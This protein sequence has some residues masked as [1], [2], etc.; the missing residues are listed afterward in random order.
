MGRNLQYI[1]S[2]K[3]IVSMNKKI[4]VAAFFAILTLSSVNA[5]AQKKKSEAQSEPTEAEKLIAQADSSHG[6]VVV[7][8]EKA[9]EIAMSENI[10][11]KIA[12][13][14]I[15][16][17]GYAKKGTYAALFPQINATGSYQRTL[18]R[19]DIRAMMGDSPMTSQL[20]N[21]TKIGNL[22]SFSLGAS[23]AMPIVNAQLWE[24]IKISSLS[25]ETAVEKARSSKLDMVTQVKSA[26]FAVLLAKEALNVYKE[27]YQ[28]AEA[29]FDKVE[30]RY[31][32]E[33]A[34]EMEYLRAKTNV[35]NAVPN[36]F[37]AENSV[38]LA[39]WQLKA[40]MGIDL[41]VDIDTEGA[42]EDYAQHMFYDV[43]QQDSLDVSSNTTL[44]Q[45]DLQAKQLERTVRL[46]KFAYI[47]TLSAQIS[48]TYSSVA[49]DP[50]R[51]LSWFP[52][53]FAGLSLNIPICSGGKRLN[54]V[55]QSKNQYQQLQ[56][57]RTN[58][59][60]Q[61]RISAQNY[62][63]TMETNMKTYYSAQSAVE[64]AQ[65][66]YDIVS[67]SYEVGRSTLTDLN[68]ATLAMVQAK[69]GQSQAIYNFLLAKTNLEQ[70]L[71]TMPEAE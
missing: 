32:N 34:S 44:R 56:L 9:L 47:P 18:I 36:V 3:N 13:A 35:A 20:G 42:L 1:C 61:L 11:V 64:S 26:Y 23:A 62:V 28:N 60:R 57:Q 14:E 58:A 25:V 45:L 48:L 40:V 27:V 4:Y 52:Y 10:S 68:D 24:S 65:K 49:N 30:K 54:D 70:L 22:N 33:K 43:H 16:R 31:Q 63:T 7:S 37:N 15:E 17:T 66:G 29:N 6:P 2:R 39:L 59:E 12:D 53:S 67:K 8:L 19:N 51:K 69:L 41:D 50:I 46:Q 5:S 55:R 71:G 38:I 21:N